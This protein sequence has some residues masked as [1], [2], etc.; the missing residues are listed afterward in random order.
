[1]GKWNVVA[2]W[3]TGLV[4]TEGHAAAIKLEMVAIRVRFE[5]PEFTSPAAAHRLLRRIGAAALESCGAS[6][7]RIVMARCWNDAVDDAV[8]RMDGAQLCCRCSES[9]S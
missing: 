9:H 7:C 3:L 2:G 1:M 8:R 5:R 4:S 6:A